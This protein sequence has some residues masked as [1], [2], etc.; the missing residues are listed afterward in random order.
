MLQKV[1]SDLIESVECKI[2]LKSDVNC[3]SEN[4]VVELPIAVRRRR[5]FTWRDNSPR[6]R[7]RNAGNSVPVGCNSRSGRTTR[8]QLNEVGL[9][10]YIKT[11][12]HKLEA[13][14]TLSNE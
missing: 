12:G 6:E 7:R 4:T 11:T 5:G 13:T 8:G 9:R 1:V 2:F 3:G 14:P 10:Y